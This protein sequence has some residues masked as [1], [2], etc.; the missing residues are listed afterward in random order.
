[1]KK[2]MIICLVFIMVLSATPTVFAAEPSSKEEVVYGILDSTG[3]VSNI[4]VVNSFSGG[5]IVDYGSY[6]SI[7]NMNT[8]DPLVQDGNTITTSTTA[9]KLYYEGKL[10]AKDL[11]WIIEIQYF[12]NGVE[13]PFKDLGGKSGSLEITI[14]TRKN[15]A[16]NSTF[17]ENYLLQISLALDTQICQNIVANNATIANVGSAKKIVHMVMPGRDA[18]I[19]ITADVSDFEMPGFEIAATPMS[20]NVSRP[21]TGNI[22]ENTTEL[23]DAMDTLSDGTKK[24]K[25]GANDLHSGAK[26]LADGSAEYKKGVNEL[27]T[28]SSELTKGSTDVKNALLYMQSQLS[29]VSFTPQDLSAL[30]TASAKVKQGITDLYTGISALKSSLDAVSTSQMETLIGQNNAMKGL[31]ATQTNLITLLDANNSA[32]SSI[33]TNITAAQSAVNQLYVGANQL[34]TEY[35]AFDTAL[36]QLAAGLSASGA[37]AKI[38]DLKDGID[39]LATKYTLFDQG[40]REYTGGVGSLASGYSEIHSGIHKISSGATEL[41]SGAKKL[42]DGT[43]ELSDAVIELP[44]TINLKIDDFMK[45][46]DKSDFVPISFVSSNNKN[47]SSVQFV[48]K[49]SPIELPKIE[50]PL[51]TETTEL[52]IWQKFL[53]LFGLKP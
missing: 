28:K 12:L 31:Y 19:R 49:T 47:V 41:T 24:M 27:N 7:R 23:T 45:E 26:E 30:T 25:D 1:M 44:D 9:E 50:E 6:I 46:Y 29:T 37:P 11:P 20:L 36:N 42:Y 2:R 18:D 52:T 33:K 40:V 5:S 48:L 16:V 13:I 15:D 32:L 21:D 51:K 17:Y 43:T 10:N 35:A 39:Q 8:N 22:G 3:S 14:Q 4:Y 38:K 34:N 53:Q